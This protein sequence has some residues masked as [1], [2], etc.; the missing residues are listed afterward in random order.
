MTFHNES[1]NLETTHQHLCVTYHSQLIWFQ[2]LTLL[3]HIM[4]EFH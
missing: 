1:K 4:Q 2:D 3:G